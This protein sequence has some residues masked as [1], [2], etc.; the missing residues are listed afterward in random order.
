M[1]SRHKSYESVSRTILLET[2][3]EMT[4]CSLCRVC[5]CESVK[6]LKKLSGTKL[7]NSKVKNQFEP[8]W[9]LKVR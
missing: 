8:H 3:G 6:I 1:L 5:V 2:E 7:K 4:G 9:K